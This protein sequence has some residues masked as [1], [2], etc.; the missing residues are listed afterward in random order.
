MNLDDQIKTEHL[1]LE[2]RVCRTC[3]TSKGLLAD[4]YRIR[5]DPSLPSSYAY[6]CK[7]CTRQR[8]KDTSKQKKKYRLGTCKI[9]GTTNT[10]LLVDFCKEC[11]KILKLYD[12]DTLKKVVVYLENEKKL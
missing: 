2:D 12:I 1:L 3:N 6:E 7:T 10:K 5:K 4:F 9:C 11:D 8:V